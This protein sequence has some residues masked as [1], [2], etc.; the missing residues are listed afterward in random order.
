MANLQDALQDLDAYLTAVSALTEF[1]TW[2][3]TAFTA[4]TESPFWELHQFV[5]QPPQEEAVSTGW[6]PPVLTAPPSPVSDRTSEESPRSED[7]SSDVD[8]VV[9]DPGDVAM[10]G[11]EDEDGGEDMEWE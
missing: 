3:L 8:S 10:W 2:E 4:L 6:Q 5:H 1:P 7:T 11:M 9:L